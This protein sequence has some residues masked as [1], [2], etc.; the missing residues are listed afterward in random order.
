MCPINTDNKSNVGNSESIKDSTIP[1]IRYRWLS[2]A[3]RCCDIQRIESEI[4]T[5]YEIPN[6]AP[7]LI[8][9]NTTN[10]FENRTIG[11]SNSENLCGLNGLLSTTISATS[12]HKSLYTSAESDRSDQALAPQ[13]IAWRKAR[14]MDSIKWATLRGVK[15]YYLKMVGL[16]LKVLKN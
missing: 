5:R 9:T 1:S 11:H 12:K 10:T 13:T 14:K 4:N 3:C 15:S 6:T 16:W 2:C 7:L 8:P